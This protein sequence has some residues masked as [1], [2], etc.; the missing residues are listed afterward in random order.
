MQEQDSDNHRGTTDDDIAEPAHPTTTI[1]I[2]RDIR[3]ETAEQ[4][5]LRL[6][7]IVLGNL[8]ELLA[9]LGQEMTPR[10]FITRF[11]SQVLIS[12]K[13]GE[14]AI[15]AWDDELLKSVAIQWLRAVVTEDSSTVTEDMTFEAVGEALRAQIDGQREIL[16]KAMVSILNPAQQVAQALQKHQDMRANIVQS[17]SAT[18]FRFA[19]PRYELP[20]LGILPML[21]SLGDAYGLTSMRTFMESNRSALD[22]AARLQT[23]IASGIASTVEHASLASSILA[24]MSSASAGVGAVASFTSAVDGLQSAISQITSS[25]QMAQASVVAAFATD[26]P[27]FSVGTI[28]PSLPDL[29]NLTPRF[30]RARRAYT[31]LEEGGFS[32]TEHL[33]NWSFL[34]SFADAG[35]KV[36][37]AAVTNRMLAYTRKDVFRQELKRTI[38][39]STVLRRRREFV[40]AALAAHIRRE[41][42]VAIPLFLAH[43]EGMIGDALII[44]GS[45]RADGY[46]LIERLPNGSDK[47]DSKGKPV[48]IRGLD[49]LVTISP[50]LQHEALEL[51]SDLILNSVAKDR[52][53]ILHGRS[54]TYDKPKFSAQLVLMIYAF[55]SEIAA[56][57]AGQV[58]W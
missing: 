34:L 19:I 9:L 48:A 14:Q 28:F 35:S 36:T 46:K 17:I 43:L 16:D 38:E 32:F 50:F 44:K 1:T 24:Q 12:P 15:V 57:E 4:G 40:E 13:L 52:N 49:R 47:L 11:I 2:P 18:R 8:P 25:A 29:T 31:A 10:T 39:G 51:A 27:K 21:N 5:E 7:R 3:I 41:Y 37:G 58:Q 6:H 20:S 26:L 45:V 56:F 22:A 54:T 23:P 53:A 33:W 55:A 30:E 42:H